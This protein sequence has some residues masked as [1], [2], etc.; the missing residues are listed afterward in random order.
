MAETVQAA[1]LAVM[2]DVRGLGK[3][4]RN[5]APNGNYNFRGI[6]DVMN[7]VG[8]ALRDHGLAV[9]PQC[10]SVEYDAVEVGAKRTPMLVARV[11][12]D[13]VFVG[14][15]GS[16]LTAT[17]PGEA[18]DSG[19]KATAKAMSVAFRTCLLQALCLPTDEPDPDVHTYEVAAR[20]WVAEADALSD[21]ESLLHLHA[22]AKAHRV[23]ADVLAHI[24]DR[25]RAL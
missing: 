16:S 2:Q 20:D 5:T 24:V 17:A 10:R 3:H 4:Q 14:P 15:D 13:Y 23:P 22:E 21:R 9:I 11:L 19:D 8:P 12:V 25:G 18:F 7:A 6:D 1:L